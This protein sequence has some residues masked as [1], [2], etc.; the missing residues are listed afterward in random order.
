MENALAIFNDAGQPEKTISVWEENKKD[1]LQFDKKT[2]VSLYALNI[3]LA[4]FMLKNYHQAVRLANKI[5]YEKS[6]PAV[7]CEARLLLLLSH[8]E[9]NTTDILSSLARQARKAYEKENM[10]KPEQKILFNFFEKKVESMNSKAEEKNELTELLKKVLEFEK[11][12]HKRTT[13]G[14][15]DISTWIEGRISGK[16]Y[17]ELIRKT[18]EEN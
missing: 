7:F 13:T 14:S 1:I 17:A 18:A 3:C 11:E 15:V 4:E 8:Y 10:L 16:T 5:P 12:S 9:L 6:R 2:S